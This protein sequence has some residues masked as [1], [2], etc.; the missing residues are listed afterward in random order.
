MTW[1]YMYIFIFIG[2]HFL[3]IMGIYLF[4]KYKAALM[5]QMMITMALSM[6]FGLVIGVLMGIIYHD[7]L[8]LSILMSMGIS[9]LAGANL[10]LRLHG[11]AGIEGFFTAI[12]AGMMGSMLVG[13]LS[14]RETII[15]FLVSSFLLI[16]TTMFSVRHILYRSCEHVIR[17]YDL[18]LLIATCCVFIITLWMFPD[19]LEQ[20]PPSVKPLH[21]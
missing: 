8:L 2:T 17:K 15:I 4:C 9:G 19:V 20:N 10:G 21:L 1:G 3:V 6:S 5:E 12:M 16:G 7:N 13:M 11:L 14:M 18:L